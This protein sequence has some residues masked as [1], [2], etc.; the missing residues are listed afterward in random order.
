DAWF[1]KTPA[2]LLAGYDPTDDPAVTTPKGFA[3]NML[4]K[5]TDIFDV[6]FESGSSW[7]AAAVQ[8][9]LV[10]DIPIDMY[11]EG[12][13]QHRGWFQ[14][15]LLPAL[16]VCGKAP[17]KTVLTH[18]FVVTEDGYKMS[19]SLGN[20]VDAVDQ[21]SKRGADILR[22]WVAGQNYQDDI[23]CSDAL[24][25]QTEDA[26]RKIRN[27]LRFC[28]GACSDFDPGA[29][30]TDPADHSVD[31]WMRLE[32]HQL[33]RDVRAAYDAYEFHKAMRLL[34]EFC[35]VQASSVYLS[36]V[37]DRLYCETPGAL[38]RRASQTVIYEMLMALVKLLA[39]VCPHTCEEAWEQIPHRPADEPASVHL[40][41]LPDCDEEMLRLAEELTP[42]TRDLATF[43]IDQLEAGP[44]W[45][46]ERLMD[47][48]A[49]GLVK[50]EALRN[51]GVKNP[52]DAEAVFVVATKN[53]DVAQLVD[54]Y[55][56]ELEDLLGVGH[57]RIER[58]DELPEGEVV[59]VR[60]VDT[61]GTYERCARSWKRRPDVGSDTTY[62]D[63][64]ARDAAVMKELK[65]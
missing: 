19:K 60:V 8:R 57:A 2:E 7:F 62:P 20:A 21:L 54:I 35:T 28:M 63:L 50:L 53:D 37:K 51:S 36:A 4:T 18:G 29:D 11:L 26:Y 52:L 31:R 5:G 39:P 34:Y 12:S 43:S 40:A 65:E 25:A 41:L 23:R 3:V 61:R 22:L 56:R 38:R 44:Q 48:R 16:G 47:L 15:S 33:I 10:D 30:A 6:W 59:D 58:S 45:V 1:T 27:T 17:F 24:I 32:L 9:K 55:I 46:W 14:L 42:V 64:S 13:D 49:A